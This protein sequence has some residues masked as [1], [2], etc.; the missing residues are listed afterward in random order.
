MTIDVTNIMSG[1][2]GGVT[3][4]IIGASVNL[5]M[6]KKNLSDSLDSKS[7]WRKQLYNAASTS[8]ITLT[9]IYRLR[10]SLRYQ[11]K[12]KNELVG[13]NSD[14]LLDSSVYKKD[15]DHMTFVMIAFCDE[16]TRK[17][18]SGEPLNLLDSELTRIYIRYLLKHQWESL[19]RG[20]IRRN[21][22]GKHQE[23][24]LIKE[25]LNEIDSKKNE[26]QKEK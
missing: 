17:Y 8:Q 20:T 25:V 11:A 10:A 22:W 4:A 14:A 1:F 13:E 16:M 2:I 26:W 24:E 6:N 7:E 9:E 18:K 5:Y 21:I 19:S 3:A 23:R 15:F 12:T